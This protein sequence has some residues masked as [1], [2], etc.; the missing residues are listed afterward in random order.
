MDMLTNV[1][2]KARFAGRCPT[3]LNSA[4]E[5]TMQINFGNRGNSNQLAIKTLKL[6]LKKLTPLLLSSSHLY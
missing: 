2:S 3:T 6:R 1:L 5:S 4:N